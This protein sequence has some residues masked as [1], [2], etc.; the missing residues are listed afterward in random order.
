MFH[1]DH[2]VLSHTHTRQVDH[3]SPSAVPSGAVAAISCSPSFVH[4]C[5]F[6]AHALA[7]AAS[8]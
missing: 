4:A 5:C 6:R 3:N 8:Q 1:V 7:A 2:L